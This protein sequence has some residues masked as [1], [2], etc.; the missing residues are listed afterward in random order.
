M[1]LIPVVLDI[2]FK[3]MFNLF[4]L[5]NTYIYAEIIVEGLNPLFDFFMLS[6]ISVYCLKFKFNF[7]HAL[8]KIFSVFIITTFE[9]SHFLSLDIFD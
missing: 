6:L 8:S 3:V 2:C 4:A 1:Q 5:Q 9:F 7:E